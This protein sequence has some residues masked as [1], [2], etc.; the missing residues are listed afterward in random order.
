MI[1]MSPC[2]TDT[3]DV[4]LQISCQTLEL[5][6]FI[7]DTTS[8]TIQNPVCVYL[9]LT[10]CFPRVALPPR[11]AAGW[12]ACCCTRAWLRADVRRS[13]PTLLAAACAVT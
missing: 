10:I 1:S 7:N 3:Y 8:I 4:R 6:Q 12:L 9:G 13:T 2:L 5:V 11:L